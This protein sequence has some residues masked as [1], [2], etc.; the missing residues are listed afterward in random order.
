MP[1]MATPTA[2]TAVT[3]ALTWMARAALG[4]PELLAHTC[5]VRLLSAQVIVSSTDDYTSGSV[6][7][8][9]D[10]HLGQPDVTLCNGATGQFVSVVLTNGQPLTI[11]ELAVMAVPAAPTEYTSVVVTDFTLQGS[12]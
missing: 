11:C 2:A 6:C 7:G 1:S 9:L 5:G 10:D 4:L 12:C 8:E 3:L